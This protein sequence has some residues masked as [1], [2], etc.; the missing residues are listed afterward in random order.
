M[1][2]PQQYIFGKISDKDFFFTAIHIK[3]DLEV[4]EGDP[5]TSKIPRCQGTFYF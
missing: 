4:L 2:P 3:Q 5:W 1:G